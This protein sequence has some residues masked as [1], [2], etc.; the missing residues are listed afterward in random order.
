[1]SL[2]NGDSVRLSA[3]EARALNQFREQRDWL[4]RAL[5]DYLRANPAATQV[6]AAAY[7][8]GLA[9]AYPSDEWGVRDRVALLAV[10]VINAGGWAALKALI[11][12]HDWDVVSRVA[13]ELGMSAPAAGEVAHWRIAGND[14]WGIPQALDAHEPTPLRETADGPTKGFL[15]AEY[16]ESASLGLCVQRVWTNTY[17]GQR[18]QRSAGPWEVMS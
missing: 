6:Q 9:D 4:K 10:Y 15:V 17:D 12:A 18:V 13:P 3:I 5:Y 1:M 8:N 14:A 16:R 7:I 11:A 2:Q